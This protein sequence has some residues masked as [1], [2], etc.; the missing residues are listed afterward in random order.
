MSFIHR[1][2][3]P[4]LPRSQSSS[5]SPPKISCSHAP[6]TSRPSSSSNCHFFSNSF[7]LNQEISQIKQRLHLFAKKLKP[8]LIKVATKETDTSLST[9]NSSDDEDL[10]C[11]KESYSFILTENRN[12]R[13]TIKKS[14]GIIEQPVELEESPKKH[15]ITEDNLLKYKFSKNSECENRNDFIEETQ[16]RCFSHIENRYR[17]ERNI[18]DLILTP[19]GLATKEKSGYGIPPIRKNRIPRPKICKSI[20]KNY[21]FKN[22]PSPSYSKKLFLSQ[23]FNDIENK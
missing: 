16:T 4:I 6:F 14:T 12:G 10:K 13:S 5:D 15:H 23:R 2:F 22:F 17:K 18:D 9:E 8:R 19:R 21:N 7:N 3:Q 1:S 11:S 20:P